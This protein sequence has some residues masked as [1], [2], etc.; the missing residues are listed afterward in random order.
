MPL[1]AADDPVG[2]VRRLRAGFAHLVKL[3]QGGRRQC[4]SLYDAYGPCADLMGYVD[5]LLTDDQ[6]DI[7]DTMVVY[8]P[9]AHWTG[10]R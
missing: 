9:D 1:C 8:V 3:D 2:T 10:G 7:L 4:W 6:V 5:A